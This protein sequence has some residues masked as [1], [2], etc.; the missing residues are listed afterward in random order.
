MDAVYTEEAHVH[1]VCTS[2]E[3]VT[4]IFALFTYCIYRFYVL[5]ICFL[6]QIWLTETYNAFY[7]YFISF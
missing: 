7:K 4:A 5:Y 1:T 6:L 2:Q 3:N